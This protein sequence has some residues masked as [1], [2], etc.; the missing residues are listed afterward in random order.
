MPRRF[1]SRVRYADVM[2]TGAMFVALGGAS[3]AAI[4]LPAGS[5]GSK[6][7][8]RAAVTPAKVAPRT[9][10]L[11]KGQQGNKGA[12]GAT[13]QTGLTGPT[14]R[15]GTDA[16]LNGAAAGGDLAGT[17]PN[18]SIAAGAVTASKLASAEAWHEVTSFG[19][20]NCGMFACTWQN[21]AG[22]TDN[23]TVAYYRDPFGTVHLKGVACAV[24][25]T[26]CDS[27]SIT[28]PTAIFTLPAGYRPAKQEVLP[29]WSNFGFGT[30]IVLS[31]GTVNA[32][33]GSNTSMSLDGLTF[34]AGG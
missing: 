2:A 9:I 15:A 20:A 10:R 34:R 32:W 1:G 27:S 8:K 5:V 7:L 14:G 16:Q 18:P 4:K 24:V 6:Q 13:G 26:S 19:A 3:Y 25:S 33:T 11:F 21:D 22:N 12:T 23:N 31:N 28:T 30:V 17:Y 29:A